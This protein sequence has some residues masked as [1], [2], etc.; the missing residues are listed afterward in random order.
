MKA[1]LLSAGLG[2]RLA[3]ITDSVPKSL[4]TV[5]GES[6]LFKQI[7]N[8]ITNGINDITIVSGYLSD[9]LKQAVWS[10]YKN[11]KIIEN[12]DYQKTNNMYSA[13]LAKELFNDELFMMN[14]D[15]FF[16]SDIIR[17]M[18]ICENKSVIAVDKGRYNNESMKVICNGNRVT[19]ISKAISKDD[20][21]GTSIDV[22]KFSKSGAK[23][24]I[25][26]CE[27]YIEENKE[28]NLW[29]EVALNDAL[30]M[31]EFL[32]CDIYGRWLEIDDKNDLKMAEDIFRS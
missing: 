1:L 17:Q 31:D 10:K 18:L 29:S 25:D 24:F 8:L 12:T 5:N 27:F 20:T 13:Y 2:S 15:V 6:I 22:Y 11:I 7:D 21:Y 4:V 26:R 30:E 23:A 16:D 28:L 9:I 3:P 14:A 32:A 19:S